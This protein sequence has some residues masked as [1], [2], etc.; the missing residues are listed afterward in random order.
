MSAAVAWT[1]VAGQTVVRDSAGVRVVENAARARAPVAFQLGAAPSLD[2]G[3]P[4]EDNPDNEFSPTQ[5]YL[6]GVRLSDNGL[7]VI[8]VVRVQFFDAAGKRVRIAGR[9]GAGPEEFRYLTSIC[10]TRGDTI[11]VSD[12]RNSRLGIL[13]RNGVIVR[14]VRQDEHGSPPFDGCFDD[15]TVLLQRALP[16]APGATRT[17]RLTRVR[18]DGTVVNA[19]GDFSF[20]AFDMVTQNAGT[21]IAQQQRVYIGDGMTS[22]IRVY[23]PA[24]KLTTIIRS[25]DPPVRITATEAE[26][27]MRS[28][29]P[30]NVPAAEAA[31]RMD[32]MRSRPRAA[33]WPAYRRVHVDPRG[34]LWVQDYT[35][36]SASPDGWTAFDADGRLIG[37][38]LIPPPAPGARRLQII[39]FGSDELL[40]RRQDED[41]FAHLSVFPIQTIRH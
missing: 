6:R 32:R 14:T 11:V 29:I 41:G 15:G 21:V 27:R 28:S 22:E 2:F 40:V 34:R 26:D 10:R 12:S 18:L 4:E 25:A 33:T 13:D 38:L 9:D 19:I 8:D 17:M 23:T 30:S 39:S 5:G 3:G 36:E 1:P 37:R 24:G 31:E 20:P 35:T 7:A 16:A